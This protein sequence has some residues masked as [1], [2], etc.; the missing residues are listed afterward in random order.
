MALVCILGINFRLGKWNPMVHARL[1]GN[2][3]LAVEEGV[4]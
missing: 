2:S 4:D 1:A 3:V